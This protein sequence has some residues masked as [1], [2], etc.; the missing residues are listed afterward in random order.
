MLYP[1]VSN[2]NVA[3]L[4]NKNDLVLETVQQIVKDFALFGIEI[5]FSG[6]VNNAYQELMEQLTKQ[7]SGLLD[8]DYQRL[9]SVLYQVD[10]SDRDIAKTS[11]EMPGLSHLEV[12]SHQV[13]VR[14]LK[15]VLLRRYFKQKDQSETDSEQSI[16][17]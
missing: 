7:I 9:L 8:A 10:I 6:D 13:I 14:D 5:T 3:T 2:S 12:I 1:N 17:E 16:V 4:L 15:K 11:Q